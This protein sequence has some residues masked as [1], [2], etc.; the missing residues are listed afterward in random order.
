MAEKAV[1]QKISLREI[2]S[3]IGADW[4][5]TS[6]GYAP[7]GATRTATMLVDARVGLGLPPVVTKKAEVAGY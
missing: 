4:V 2:C 5:K 1:P 7:S 6:T 3:E